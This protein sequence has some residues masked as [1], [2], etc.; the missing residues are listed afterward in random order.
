MQNQTRRNL[1]LA[2][3]FLAGC[4]A[5]RVQWLPP[6]LAQTDMGMPRWDYYCMQPTWGIGT[7]RV[8]ATTAQLKAAGLLGWELVTVDNYTTIG[9]EPA[10]YCFKRPL[11]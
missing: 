3:V 10:T 5:S 6:A 8:E 7:P 4:A 1:L 2:L 11:R 9:V